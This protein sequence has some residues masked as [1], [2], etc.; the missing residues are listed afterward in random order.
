MQKLPDIL[1]QEAAGTGLLSVSAFAWS[2]GHL[3]DLHCSYDPLNVENPKQV[4]MKALRQALVHHV[5]RASMNKRA[6]LTVSHG[7]GTS[8]ALGEGAEEATAGSH[9]GR[10]G[11]TDGGEE[12]HKEDGGEQDGVSKEEEEV[13]H[14]D[15]DVMVT[16]EEEAVQFAGE[17]VA[18]KSG[19]SGPKSGKKA[20]ASGGSTPTMTTMAS[21]A[22]LERLKAAE[23][24]NKKLRE[25]KL[26]A[27][28]MQDDQRARIDRLFDVVNMA[29]QKLSS[30]TENQW[31]EIE[32]RLH[33][34]RLGE[35]ENL[36][37]EAVNIPPNQEAPSRNQEV[38][39]VPSPYEKLYYA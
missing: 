33:K 3:D 28:K 32:S 24:E 10:H 17:K 27:E 15:D 5:E 8:I 35:W 4:C 36:Y 26:V 22:A 14:E 23:R 7:V 11:P 20:R 30:V 25:E 18:D 2:L 12:E 37:N 13:E 16:G 29:V 19:D 38:E 34:F 21:K 1:R 31:D 9:S 39:F 6:A